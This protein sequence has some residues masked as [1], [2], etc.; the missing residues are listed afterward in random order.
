VSISKKLIA[1]QMGVSADSSLPSGEEKKTDEM[2]QKLSQSEVNQHAQ[3][4]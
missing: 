4:A 2:L 3:A 1:H